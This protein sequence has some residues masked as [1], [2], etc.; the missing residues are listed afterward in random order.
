MLTDNTITV[1]L[2][3]DDDVDAMAVQR[4]FKNARIANQIVRAKDGIDALSI[5]N[6]EQPEKAIKKPFIIL[7]DLNMPRMD[8]IAFLKELRA[9]PDLGETIVFVL[10]TSKADEDRVKAYEQHVA[11]FIIKSDAGAGFLELIN[12]LEHYWRVVVLP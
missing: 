1:L 9:D 7:L 8:G 2:V 12:M 11:G 3:E 10:T 5:L 6:G 4:G